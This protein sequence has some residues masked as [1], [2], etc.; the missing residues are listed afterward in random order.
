MIGEDLIYTC[1]IFKDPEDT[2]EVAQERKF[3][4]TAA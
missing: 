4:A 2:L 1:A 3:G